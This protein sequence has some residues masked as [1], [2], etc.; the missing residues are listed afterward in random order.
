MNAV[1]PANTIEVWSADLDR[2]E[3][4]IPARADWLSAEEHERLQRQQ[5][6][7]QRNRHL[8]ARAWLRERLAHKLGL[9]PLAVS[10]RTGEFGKP[11]LAFD[12][13]PLRFNLSHTAAE[14]VAAFS[15][16]GEVGIDLEH[17]QSEMVTRETAALFLS[18]DELARV[19]A[20]EGEERVVE[21][22]RRWTLK[23]A[24]LKAAGTGL[25]ADPREIVLV[26]LA[27]DGGWRTEFGGRRWTAC[28]FSLAPGLVGAVAV[29]GERCAVAWV[30]DAR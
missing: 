22:F 20:L 9:E 12:P 24:V 26:P 13:A 10:L 6:A 7:I 29:A 21:F 2:L 3:K 18:A 28:E 25:H 4:A 11:E 17:V 19:F 14:V 8:T 30:R 5:N 23:E 16:D 15:A 27:D 1:A